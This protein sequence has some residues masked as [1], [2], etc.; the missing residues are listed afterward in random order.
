[1]AATVTTP[2]LD[3]RVYTPQAIRAAVALIESNET[4][5]RISPHSC[6]WRITLVSNEQPEEECRQDLLE[7]LNNTLAES[8]EQRLG[9]LC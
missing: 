2:N 4:S 7:L 3:L 6:G 5:V 1:M 9:T 8:L